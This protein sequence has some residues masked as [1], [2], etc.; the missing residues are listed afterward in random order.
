[1]FDA[2]LSHFDT[3]LVLKAGLLRHK[4]NSQ[5]RI[6]IVSVGLLSRDPG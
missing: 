1:M 2:A 4:P 5:L 3:V 6:T